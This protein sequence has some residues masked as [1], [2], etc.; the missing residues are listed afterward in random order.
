MLDYLE[1]V[2]LGLPEPIIL[3]HYECSDCGTTWSDEWTCACDDR[4]P[5]CNTSN[6]PFESEEL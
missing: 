4:C 5:E 2:L 6:A 3:N 1:D